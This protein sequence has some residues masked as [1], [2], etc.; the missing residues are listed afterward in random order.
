MRVNQK[1][2]RAL[3]ICNDHALVPLGHDRFSEISLEDVG[4]VSQH[5]WYARK[6]T[7]T[8]YV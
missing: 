5:N 4:R 8:D 1:N 2:I 3:I 6:D 7:R